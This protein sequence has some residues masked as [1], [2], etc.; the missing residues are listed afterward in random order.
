MKIYI[1]SDHRGVDVENKI[2]DYL[3]QMGLTVIKSEMEHTPTDD[4]VDFAIELSENVAK[5]SE[6]LGILLCGTGIGMSIAANKVNGIRAARCVDVD[7]AFY[8]K[9]HNSANV[10][11]L[12]SNIEIN[13]LFEII[14]TFINTKCATEEKH[15]NR[16]NKIIKYEA[17]E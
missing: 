6:S 5:D 10:I 11:C 7:D 2:T 16:V 4:Y 15:I 17:G 12:S 13:Y 3:R 8:S 9:N 1:A 14:D